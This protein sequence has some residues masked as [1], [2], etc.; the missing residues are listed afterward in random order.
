[1]HVHRR[2]F[3]R[4]VQTAN[5]RCESWTSNRT[6]S[7]DIK[8]EERRTFEILVQR[9]DPNGRNEDMSSVKTPWSL[10]IKSHIEDMDLMDR[11]DAIVRT[12]RGNCQEAVAKVPEILANSESFVSVSDSILTHYQ[13]EEYPR[14]RLD[15]KRQP[16]DSLHRVYSIQWHSRAQ[17]CSVQP[18]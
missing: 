17:P 15:N 6:F 3:K 9:S 16:L 10:D 8:V 2:H 11:L 18:T 5:I 4:A 14:R 1:M 12:F 13:I 7:N